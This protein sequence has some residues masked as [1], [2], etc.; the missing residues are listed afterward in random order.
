MISV[1]KK[2]KIGERD[3]EDMF[4]KGHSKTALLRIPWRKGLNED[5]QPSLIREKTA[6]G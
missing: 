2:N 6:P 1:I 5:S 4:Q 3:E